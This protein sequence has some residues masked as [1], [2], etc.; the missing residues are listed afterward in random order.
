L[1]LLVLLLRQLVNLF[2]QL[3]DCGVFFTIVVDSVCAVSQHFDD[4][5]LGR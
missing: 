1:S 3:S 2:A 4:F 5:F